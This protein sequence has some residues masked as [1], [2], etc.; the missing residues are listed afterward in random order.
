MFKRYVLIHIFSNCTLYLHVWEKLYSWSFDPSKD[1]HWSLS[2]VENS[3]QRHANKNIRWEEWTSMAA[4]IL[5]VQSFTFVG[6]V[7]S[8]W[9][10]MSVSWL[11]GLFGW[12]VMIPRNVREF[13]FP[14]SYILTYLV[15]SHPTPPPLCSRLNRITARAGIPVFEFPAGPFEG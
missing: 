4:Y 13:S 6:C 9:T 2:Y 7:I 3:S 11:V 8:L 15:P 5:F 12:S 1:Y 14:C 10:P